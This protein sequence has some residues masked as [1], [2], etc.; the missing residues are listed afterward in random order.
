MRM[1]SAQGFTLLELTM[2]VVVVGVVLAASI[3][4]FSSYRRSY[5]LRTAT[6]SIASQLRLTR[7]KAMVSDSLQT[8]H[9]TLDYLNSDYH[10]HNGTVVSPKWSL[11]EGITYYWGAGTASVFR[12]TRAGRC[13]D[14]G[15]V[16]IQSSS[17]RRDTVSVLLSGLVLVK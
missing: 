9:F 12:M 16:I 4:S 6:E 15:F 5:E 13:M 17:G 8:M 2:V 11:P 3:P 14:S 10:I 7:E 1:R